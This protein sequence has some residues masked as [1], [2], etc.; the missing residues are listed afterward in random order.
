MK[1]YGLTVVT[2]PL[3]LGFGKSPGAGDPHGKTITSHVVA[4]PPPGF[5][6]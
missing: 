3:G 2:T 5:T 1:I 4:V 6:G